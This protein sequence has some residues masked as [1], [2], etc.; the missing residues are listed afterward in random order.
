SWVAGKFRAHHPTTGFVFWTI[1]RGTGSSDNR[2]IAIDRERDLA[3]VTRPG[4]LAAINLKEGA[5]A[6]TA[7]GRFV[8]SPVVANGVVYAIV[9]DEVR[10]FDAADGTFLTRYEA[11]WASFENNLVV[12]D[13][14][15]FVSGSYST[16]IFDLDH[17]VPQRTI[18]ESGDLALANDTLY[19]TDFYTVYAYDLTPPTTAVT[20][21]IRGFPVAFETPSPDYGTYPVFVGTPVT[22]SIDGTSVESN[23]T[24]HLYGGWSGFG[25]AAGSGPGT[26]VS[27]TAHTDALVNWHW[28]RE[29]Y[30]DTESTAHGSIDVGD[31][32]QL[33]NAS[34]VITATADPGST[35]IG[36]SGDAPDPVQNPLTLTMDQAR[37]I[38]AN[39]VQNDVLSVTKTASS[40]LL[41]QGSNLTYVIEVS[42]LGVTTVGDIVL[43]DQLPADVHFVGSVPSP[44]IVSPPFFYYD[45]PPLAPGARA[46][47]TMEVAVAVSSPGFMVNRAHVFSGVDEL[48][49]FNNIAEASTLIPD[50][51]FDGVAN[52]VDLDDDNDGAEDA[53]EA[54]AG[55]DP[56]DPN[57]VLQLQLE[58]TA[59]SAVRRLMF[60]TVPNRTY[61]VESCYDLT[62]PGWTPIQAPVPGDGTQKVLEDTNPADRVYYR[63]RVE[64]P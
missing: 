3:F 46:A 50:S 48:N 51:D 62:V 45:L 16:Y 30:L 11:R 23:G 43:T 59:D 39:F 14:T 55:T 47:V 1:N 22:L 8:Y 58:V 36:W 57:S 20:V 2:V 33:D 10:A 31:G 17:A 38:T 32:W 49:T 4:E 7:S 63:I 34:V 24:R 41:M 52:P 5:V 37:N 44:G 29:H 15:L 56:L 54:I 19:I 61:R 6:W 42:N 27:F 35:F 13:N 9:E 60:Q 21:E 18:P 64:S 25:S 40:T 28:T 53:D 26:T 12:S